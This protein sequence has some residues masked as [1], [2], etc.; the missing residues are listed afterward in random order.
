MPQ[1]KEGVEAQIKK[2]DDSSSILLY[3]LEKKV[4]RKNLEIRADLY[5]CYPHKLT[6][7]NKMCTF[8]YRHYHTNY[9]I[10][11]KDSY[12]FTDVGFIFPTATIQ[13]NFVA[14]P[15]TFNLD[16]SFRVS[17]LFEYLK[18]P[19]KQLLEKKQTLNLFSM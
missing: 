14:E 2:K 4:L 10:N 6:R 11:C 15:D 12:Q 17:V 19:M 8:W 1:K 7:V 9:N 5:F 18:N 16:K 13:E 3:S